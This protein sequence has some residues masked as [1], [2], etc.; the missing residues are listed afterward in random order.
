MIDE[1]KR[2]ALSIGLRAISGLLLFVA[3]GYVVV[4]QKPRT[5]E[6]SPV[7]TDSTPGFVAAAVEIERL[8]D[9]VPA[10]MH[11]AL[12]DLSHPAEETEILAPVCVELIRSGSFEGCHFDWGPHFTPVFHWP[13]QSMRRLVNKKG[14]AAGMLVWVNGFASINEIVSRIVRD[15]DAGRPCAVLGSTGSR[16]IAILDPETSCEVAP[17]VQAALDRHTR[18]TEVAC[19]EIIDQL[20][21]AGLAHYCEPRDTLAGLPGETTAFLDHN[22]ERHGGF[23]IPQG[24]AGLD[25]SQAAVRAL[26]H[27]HPCEVVGSRMSA[28]MAVMPSTLDCDGWAPRFQSILQQFPRDP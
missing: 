1:K 4:G 12:D 15:D 25:E 26:S 14:V 21:D 13:I 27:A 22:G 10:T 5:T 16:M 18:R 11:L 17:A 19:R 2:R 8:R 9:A 23:F 28:M 7:A 3:V 24:D 20:A 6:P